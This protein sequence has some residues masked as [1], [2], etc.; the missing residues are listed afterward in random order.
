MITPENRQGYA[1]A[2]RYIGIA[3]LS[4]MVALVSVCLFFYIQVSQLQQ[5]YGGEMLRT[6]K[7]LELVN[8][9]FKNKELTQDLLSAHLRTADRASKDS[10]HRELAKAYASNEATIRELHTVLEQPELRRTLHS[11]S[12]DLEQYH[13]HADSLIRLSR[14]QQQQKATAYN[15]AHVTPFYIR[16]QANLINLSN[17]LTAAGKRHTSEFFPAVT[18]IIDNYAFLLLLAAVCIIWAA[19]ASGSVTR[20]LQHEN[21]RLSKEIEEREALQL[22][23][24][25][26]QLHFKRLFDLNPIPLFVYDQDTYRFLEVNEAAVQEY[27]YTSEE[28]RKMTIL[29][30]R[31]EEEREKTKRHLSQLDKAAFA[32]SERVLHKRKDGSVF[33]VKLKSHAFAAADG[34][35]PRLVTSENV[36]KQEDFIEELH[37]REQQLREVSSSIPGAVYQF[38]MDADR[39]MSIPFLSGGITRL[40]GVTPEAVYQDLNILFDAV[41]PDDLPDVKESIALATRHFQPWVKDF[42]LWNK[43][44]QKWTWIRG[45]GLPSS[46]ED[47]TLIYNGTFIDITDQA[48]AQQQLIASEANLRALLDSSPQAIYLLDKG[49]N[50]I[51]F[52]AVAAREVKQLTLRELQAGQSILSITAEE[53]KSMLLESHARAMQGKPTTY[54]TG[55]GDF[56]FEVAY[57]P[58]MT[59][60]QEIIAVAMSIH[61]I[62]EQRK[63]IAAIR[64]NEAQLTRAQKLAKLGSWEYDILRDTLTI[65]DNLYNIYGIAPHTFTVTF[66]SIVSFFHPDDR[67][68]ALEAFLRVIEEKT[69]VTTEHRIQ[70]KDGSVKYMH[71]TMEPL[72]THDGQVL[73]VTGTAQ[74]ITEQKQKEME[75]REAKDLFQS[76]I[77]NIPEV[78]FSADADFRIF[79]ISPQCSYV[80]GYTEKEFTEDHLWPKI[81]HEDD[82][83][84]LR[85][86]LEEEVPLGKKIQHEMRI[87]ARDGREKW[88]LLRLSPMLGEEGKILRLDASAADITERKMVEA[89]RTL[90]TEQLQ[91]QNQ[92]LQQFAY[93]VS[94]NLRAPIANILGLTRV[95]DRQRP[96][97]ELNRHIIDSLAKSA[98]NLDN[99]IRDLN[100]ILTVRGQVL[101]VSEEVLFEEL[102]Q[103]ILKSI[104]MEL[105]KSGAEVAY[106]FSEAPGIVSLRSYVYS[107]L[108]NLITNAVKYRDPARKPSIYLRTYKEKDYICIEVSDNGLGIDLAK[109]RGSLFGLY[110]RFHPHIEGRGLGLHLVKT[111]VDLLEGKIEV[112]SQPGKG[113]TF[114]VYI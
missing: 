79:Y 84:A 95:Y 114:K 27:G 87:I 88:V 59:Q 86:L 67:N 55:F 21:D 28:F 29:D 106:D 3:F 91:L 101:S 107:I 97:S 56:W 39:H 48:E 104:S 6:Y 61:N 51:L 60:Q 8:S 99:I 62:S 75:V 102:L 18:D 1:R 63:I 89:K 100:Y 2:I 74:D 76:T 113:T 15:R 25:Q 46:K 111:Q 20:R 4:M 81:I 77:E 82:Y 7:R 45:H 80:T 43:V 11:I 41:H 93:I 108:Q 12:Q 70:L 98:Q 83:P 71:Q 105:E 16:H 103:D 94:H 40:F 31:P 85:G 32:C 112:D 38:R 42:R 92:N 57:R 44:R 10:I 24:E 23:L 69:A 36:Q 78:I 22:K 52:N 35:F 5:E 68:D 58:V 49:L 90:L 54:E 30:I 72:V 26:T 9:L 96:E 34:A 110:K 33:W 65:S 47:G 66:N 14:N 19:F 109:V 17:G 73:K 64:N 50:V 53:Q 13:A 37:K